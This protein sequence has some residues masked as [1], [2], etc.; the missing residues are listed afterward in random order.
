MK[1]NSIHISL[2]NLDFETRTFKQANSIS[3]I[4][5]LTQLFYLGFT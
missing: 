5:K 2:T 3:E 1:I 4:K